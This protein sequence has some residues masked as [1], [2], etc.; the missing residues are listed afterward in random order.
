MIKNFLN[1]ERHHNPFSGSKVTAILLKGWILPI[2]E[3][4]SGRVCSCS[5][6]SRLV[7]EY[8]LQSEVPSP[9]RFKI[10][11]GLVQAL[12][13]DGWMKNADYAMLYLLHDI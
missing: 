8:S 13:T 10:K 5:L 3:A 4:T 7:Y 6:S 11:G 12:H 2:G 9:I 1:P